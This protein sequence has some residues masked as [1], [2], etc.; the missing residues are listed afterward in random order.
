MG[1]AKSKAAKKKTTPAS[2][3][4]TKSVI[5]GSYA[6]GSSFMVNKSSF[7]SA[8]KGGITSTPRKAK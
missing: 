6:R 2:G 4:V 7:S 5:P 8:K 1:K 3:M